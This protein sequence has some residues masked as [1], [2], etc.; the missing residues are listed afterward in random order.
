ELSDLKCNKR[1]IL[2]PLTVA[3]SSFAPHMCEE[4]WKS[5]GHEGG[6]S[7]VSFPEF[8]ES[9]LVE[10]SISYPI[11]FNGKTRLNIEM[12]ADL[13]KEQVEELVLA[14]AD[15]IERLEGATPKKVIVVPKRIVN[16]VV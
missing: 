7:G 3:L 4:I 1:Q 11:S 14:H 9:F 6:I 2:E 10:D 16:I 5:L 13:S 8:D 12:G 15:V